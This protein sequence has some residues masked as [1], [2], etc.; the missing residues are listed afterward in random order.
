MVALADDGGFNMTTGD[1]E[2]AQR[3]GA[4]VVRCGSKVNLRPLCDPAVRN[5][6]IEPD[7]QFACG[8]L[9]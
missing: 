3:S 1:L 4:N 6:S 2:A 8:I 9:I 5:G 7:G